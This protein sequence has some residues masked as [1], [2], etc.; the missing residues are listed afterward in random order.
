L[1]IVWSGEKR[2]SNGGIRGSSLWIKWGGR[3][4][5]VGR[6]YV[7]LIL[8]SHHGVH[9][10]IRRGGEGICDE[11]RECRSRGGSRQYCRY[12]WRLWRGRSSNWKC[13]FG[14]IQTPPWSE[15]E[16]RSVLIKVITAIFKE[17]KDKNLVREKAVAWFDCWNMIASSLSPSLPHHECS[18]FASLLAL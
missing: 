14:T 16:V 3:G 12:M 9:G 7:H 10:G 15:E 2:R 5:R 13:R 11:R 8:L 18:L 1:R 4:E 6:R 17:K